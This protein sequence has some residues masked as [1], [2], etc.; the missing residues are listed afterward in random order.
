MI[1]A[2]LGPKF[3]QITTEVVPKP[4]F[5]SLSPAERKERPS[6]GLC[7]NC[8]EKY[9][10]SH[11][12]KVRMFR[13]TYKESCLI[14]VIDIDESELEEFRPPTEIV[15]AEGQTEINYRAFERHIC[16]NT[17]ILEGFVKCQSINVLIDIGSTHNFIQE[18]VAFIL[19]LAIHLIQPFQVSTGSG[20]K[21]TCDKL[22]KEWK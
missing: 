9:D 14:E 13:L 5:K 1:G 7:F 18:D 17:I 21:L 15:S 19:R 2:P 20:E 8:D 12:C 4:I 16:S 22:C 10:P 6:K 3:N 11:K